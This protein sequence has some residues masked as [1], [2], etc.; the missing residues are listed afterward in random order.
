[1]FDWCET[2]MSLTGCD[3]TTALREYAAIHDPEYDPADWETGE[4]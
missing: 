3:Y 4:Y 2:L 1:M